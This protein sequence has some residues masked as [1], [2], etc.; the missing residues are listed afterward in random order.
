MTKQA[1]ET[2]YQ[3]KTKALETEYATKKQTLETE[4]AAR[5]EVLETDN[6]MKKELLEA[7]YR[8]TLETMERRSNDWKDELDQKFEDVDDQI[9][10]L[11]VRLGDT[12]PSESGYNEGQQ[13]RKRDT[14][15]LLRCPIS[16]DIM[17]DQVMAA[18]G[19]TYVRL[20]I[21]DIFAQ[22]PGSDEV[23]SPVT[24]MPLAHRYLVPNLAVQD[25]VSQYS[26]LRHGEEIT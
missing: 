10:K 23:L 3:R 26:T 17:V 5:K 2:D 18:D 20:M 6:A 4:N 22:T 11:C 13:E 15:A 1:Q 21:G 7:W 8:E 9:E 14:A 24:G 19:Y 12:K 25:T 16:G